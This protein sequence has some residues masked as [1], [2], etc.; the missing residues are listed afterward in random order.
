MS[1][2]WFKLTDIVS[3]PGK[4]CFQV[5]FGAATFHHVNRLK[6]IPKYQTDVEDYHKDEA[7]QTEFTE[8][9]ELIP[10][11]QCVDFCTYCNSPSMMYMA[12]KN[13][14]LV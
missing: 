7:L 10:F 2:E 4:Q 1:L 13:K 9:K 3:N 14:H 5:K 6:R 8:D 11:S 12:A